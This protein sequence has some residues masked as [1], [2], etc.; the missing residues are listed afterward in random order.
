MSNP[1]KQLEEIQKNIVKH[2]KE[3]IFRERDAG[4]PTVDDKST[5]PTA[6]KIAQLPAGEKLYATDTVESDVWGYPLKYALLGGSGERFL[7]DTAYLFLKLMTEKGISPQN[8]AKELYPE[9]EIMNIKSYGDFLEMLGMVFVEFGKRGELDK[10]KSLRTPEELD[11][12]LK[13]ET[14]KKILSQNDIFNDI[15]F[16]ENQMK[17]I[18]EFNNQA[19]NRKALIS[20]NMNPS[21]SNDPK[22]RAL[23]FWQLQF[24]VRVLLHKPKYNY[25]EVFTLAGRFDGEAQRILENFY[26]AAL[27]NQAMNLAGRQYI[28]PND[29]EF[30]IYLDTALDRVFDQMKTH[31]DPERENFGAWAFTVMKNHI[32]NQIRSTTEQFIQ[33]ETVAIL[34]NAELREI[35]FVEPLDSNSDFENLYLDDSIK[36]PRLSD[37]GYIYTFKS[38]R[39][40]GEFLYDN[41]KKGTF[42]NSLTQK[43]RRVLRNLGV[44]YAPKASG[45]NSSVTQPT[46]PATDEPIDK[47]TGKENRDVL[48]TKFGRI[49]QGFGGPDYF[50]TGNKTTPITQELK[51]LQEAYN[52][53]D[54][55]L[56][57]AFLRDYGKLAIF[58][59]TQKVKDEKFWA[60]EPS[61]EF[62]QQLVKKYKIDKKQANQMLKGGRANMKVNIPVGDTFYYTAPNSD[63]KEV[64]PELL[65]DMYV[66]SRWA[67]VQSKEATRESMIA[68][69]ANQQEKIWL[70]E[71][72]T[73][74]KEGRAPAPIVTFRNYASASKKEIDNLIDKSIN[75]LNRLTLSRSGSTKDGKKTKE[76]ESKI[77]DVVTKAQKANI[78]KQFMYKLASGKISENEKTYLTPEDWTS[79]Y[80]ILNNE[81]VIKKIKQIRNNAALVGLKIIDPNFASG[82]FT[83][84]DLNKWGSDYVDKIVKKFDKDQK[85]RTYYLH[86]LKS[87]LFSQLTPLQPYAKKITDAYIEKKYYQDMRDL[88]NTTASQLTGY[89][90]NLLEGELEKF[91][92]FINEVKENIFKTSL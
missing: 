55:E 90:L 58:M 81:S 41:G 11:S 84:D 47:V 36:N 23:G 66:K 63:T 52:Y 82:K 16:E 69:F 70:D 30:Q 32:I 45:N 27:K 17:A 34:D 65:D 15:A 53:S 57:S 59:L 40:L 87:E 86:N 26:R 25:E 68:K 44:L 6:E 14:A 1:K 51:E 83:K 60:T 79:V 13:S 91:K 80:E 64:F 31:Y 29:T 89:N 5:A 10:I 74:E 38:G 4:E 8:A 19:K 73:A 75:K 12:L 61:V 88:V 3:S 7:K 22:L 33:P 49:V 85:A 35:S 92:L 2:V 54:E 78:R 77:R 42:I 46:A 43:S 67:G 24:L 21:T 28:N 20:F 37:E 76:V 18:S 71:I 9:S 48:L 72:S 56:E 50:L 39:D 62:I